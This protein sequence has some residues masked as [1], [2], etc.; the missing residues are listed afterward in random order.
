MIQLTYDLK[1]SFLIDADSGS[2]NEELVRACFNNED[3]EI[4]L[5]IPP[6]SNQTQDFVSWLHT[7]SGLYTVKSTYVMA[8]TAAF[9]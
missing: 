3:A 1:V 9:S 6:S 2:W 5:K 8:R 4:I 7:R